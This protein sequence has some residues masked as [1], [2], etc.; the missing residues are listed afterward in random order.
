MTFVKTGNHCAFSQAFTLPGTRYVDF[1]V[2][3]LIAM[4]IMMSCMWGV[5][6][7]IIGKRGKKLLRRMIATPMLK[8][9]FLISIMAV[10]I[11]MN[12]VEGILLFIFAHLVFNITIQGSLLATLI[13]FIAGN[14]M[15]A[16]IAVLVSSTDL[17]H[18]DGQRDDTRF[19][20]AHD[21][22]IRY[23]LQLS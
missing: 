23:L 17:K 1:L 11:G 19:C 20:N 18:R 22:T 2:L 8:S 6:Y 15:F 13:L 21:G 9:H 10:R 3:G 12:F 7:G 14:I 16:G 5:S 4:G